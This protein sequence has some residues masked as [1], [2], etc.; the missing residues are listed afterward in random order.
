MAPERILDRIIT[1]LQ[2]LRKQ[3]AEKRTNILQVALA[4]LAGCGRGMDAASHDLA[5]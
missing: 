3:K 2:A 5:P 1:A 4:L